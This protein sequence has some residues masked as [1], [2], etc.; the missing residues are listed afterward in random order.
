M[1]TLIP[2][3]LRELRALVD[4]ISTSVDN[5]E[6]ACIASGQPFPSLSEPFTRESEA[7]RLS[8]AVQQAGDILVAA[9]AQLTAV[10]RSPTATAMIYGM[11]VWTVIVRKISSDS[12]TAPRLCLRPSRD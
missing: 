10:V 11:Q 2:N 6:H 9:A 8:P 7:I 4:L 3:S 1:S 5:I 12:Y